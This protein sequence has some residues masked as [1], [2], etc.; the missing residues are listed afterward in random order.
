ME[1]I[2]I[3]TFLFLPEILVSIG[4]FSLINRIVFIKNSIKTLGEISG[5]QN[6]KVASSAGGGRAPSTER[7]VYY[8]DVHFYDES[9][10]R[11]NCIV[12]FAN[13]FLSRRVGD[14]VPIIYNK[15]NP[16]ISFLNHWFIVW[17]TPVS[18]LFIGIALLY[19]KYKKIR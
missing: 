8:S 11:H 4:I 10:C 18:I 15:K 6:Y 16:K 3:Y 1:N 17:V 2:I 7:T 12:G 19:L 14:K 5:V 13:R 9:G